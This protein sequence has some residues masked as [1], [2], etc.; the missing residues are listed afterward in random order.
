MAEEDAVAGEV[1]RIAADDD[2]EQ[3]PATAE[4]VERRRLARGFA[5]RGDARPQGDQEFQPL[6]MGDDRGAGDPG[7]LA[8]AAGRDQHA[9]IAEPVGRL[10]DLPQV[11]V[12]ARAPADRR[13]EMGAVAAG[14]QEPEEIEWTAAGN[15][16]GASNQSR[17]F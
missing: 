3:Q 6:G 5:G 13:A 2:V 17:W 11:A 4:A 1:G 12:A 10:G 7:I 14:R 8:A 16:V 15:F 9:E